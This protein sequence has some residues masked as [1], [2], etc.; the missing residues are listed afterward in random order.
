MTNLKTLILDTTKIKKLIG[1]TEALKAVETAFKYYGQGKVS[2][3]PKLYLDLKKYNGDFRAMPSYIEDI[4]SCAIKWVNV[5]PDNTRKNLPT[6]MGILILSDPLN[7]FPLCIMDATY[8]TALRTGAAGGIA[9]KYLA[10]KNSS[11]IAL[12]GCGVQAKTQLTAIN[13]LFR[14]DTVNV[15]GKNKK[16]A[17][18]FIKDIKKSY[19]LKMTG[20]DDIKECVK[21]A[22]IIVTTTPSKKPILKLEWLKNTAHINAIGADAQGK[23]ELDP[24]ILK[25]SKLVIDSWAQASHSGEINVPLRKNLITKRDIYSDIGKIAAGIKKGRT[26]K[27][28]LTVFDSTGLAIQDAAI[29]LLIYKTAIRK[30][31]GTWIKII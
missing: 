31:I 9:A 30:K 17:E 29:S 10:K 28:T 18:T 27:D 11:I 26:A 20:F 4:N 13:E 2:M 7:G 14:I 15:C 23:Q 16:E 12:V 22:D 3:P 6:V 8:A 5:H 25:K 1:M 24:R 19:N 21:D